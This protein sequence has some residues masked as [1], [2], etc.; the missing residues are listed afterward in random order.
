MR[1]EALGFP[2]IIC[3]STEEFQDQEAGVGWV[4]DQ[5]GGKGLGTFG[6]TFEI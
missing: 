5:D 6:I 2:M 1:G 4:G 3:P